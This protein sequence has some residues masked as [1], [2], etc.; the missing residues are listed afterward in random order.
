MSYSFFIDSIPD[1]ADLSGLIHTLSYDDVAVHPNV[2]S[3]W[4]EV[5]H[6]HREGISTR[7]IETAIE[8]DTLQIRIFSA[9]SP[10]DYELGL[11]LVRQAAKLYSGKITSE[12]GVTVSADELHTRYGTEWYQQHARTTFDMVLDTCVKESTNLTINGVNGVMTLGPR[13]G[14]LLQS[15]NESAAE[16]YYN[17][18][19]ELNFGVNGYY[20]ALVMVVEGGK[21]KREIRIAPIVEG[22]QT[23]LSTNVPV[24]SFKDPNSPGDPSFEIRTG[25]FIKQFENKIQWL[26][27]DVF[28]ID[29]SE[30]QVWSEIIE[31]AR[32]A[33]I[34]DMFKD[35]SLLSTVSD[36]EERA[37]SA[38]SGQA[39]EQAITAIFLVV[40]AADGEVDKKELKAFVNAVKEAV[41][42]QPEQNVKYFLVGLA[43]LEVNLSSLKNQGA[44]HC[45]EVLA[46]ARVAAFQLLSE[47][48]ATTYLNALY[49]MGENIA[50]ASGG[51]I[52]GMGSK[53]GKEEKLALEA[54][55]KLLLESH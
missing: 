11:D 35:D 27:E 52:L 31:W 32:E 16:K 47:S 53:I 42:T 25:D 8:D 30:A 21:D 1:S 15:D 38:D 39:L 43:N 5:A 33:Q 7:S 3:G 22:M 24:L 51:G 2:D 4:P 12:E 44:M 34:E 17:N 26:S 55:K 49:A 10:E 48:D 46:E 50:S 41:V 23:K 20:D 9:S 45:L 14:A 40:A 54:I 36:N 6:I 18:F 29:G 28:V 13:M 19:R 37:A